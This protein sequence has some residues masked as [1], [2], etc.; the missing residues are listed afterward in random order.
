[1]QDFIR[2][3]CRNFSESEIANIKRAAK[4][5]LTHKHTLQIHTEKL[6]EYQMTDDSRTTK[7]EG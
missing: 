6:L 4:E 3:R 5:V 1:M 2:D 7:D